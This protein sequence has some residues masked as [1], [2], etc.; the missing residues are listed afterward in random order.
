[1]NSASVKRVYCGNGYDE[2]GAYLILDQIDREPTIRHRVRPLNCHIELRRMKARYCIGRYDIDTFRDDPCPH[3]AKLSD[4]GDVCPDCFGAIGFNP[5]FYNARDRIS[6]KQARYNQQP[7]VVYL[8]WFG[9]GIFK[10]G[11]SSRARAMHRLLGQ[12]TRTAA[13][14]AELS[15]A[16]AARNIEAQAVKH[17]GIRETLRISLK[18][19]GLEVPMV[20]RDAAKEIVPGRL[21]GSI[22]TARILSAA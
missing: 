13:I 10:V 2:E 21:P 9:A 12:G 19:V 22:H 16:D 4:S 3:R 7:H 20:W 5:A 6:E 8:A 1:M 14:L 11:I 18:I 15:N 17:P